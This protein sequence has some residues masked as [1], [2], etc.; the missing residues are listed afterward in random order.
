M[1]D[2]IELQIPAAFHQ[3]FEQ[4]TPDEALFWRPNRCVGQANNFGLGIGEDIQV[5]GGSQPENEL[6]AGDEC[7]SNRRVRQNVFKQ[8]NG[9]SR[10]F[11]KRLNIFLFVIFLVL[12]DIF[13]DLVRVHVLAFLCVAIHHTM[14]GRV[15][16]G[17]E[18]RQFWRLG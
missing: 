2:S 15:A 1:L 10:F 12:G 5:G 18:I 9:S 17:C 14:R 11:D 7:Y 3:L 13:Q 4:L 16:K 6:W 8:H